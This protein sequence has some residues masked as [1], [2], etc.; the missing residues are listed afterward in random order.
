M[1]TK[2]ENKKEV[3]IQFLIITVLLVGM[4]LLAISLKLTEGII[5]M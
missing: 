2:T 1:K 3:T 5:L 4:Y